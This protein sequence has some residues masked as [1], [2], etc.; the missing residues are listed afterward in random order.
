MSQAIT[1][2]DPATNRSDGVEVTITNLADGDSP[3][4]DLWVL[5]AEVVNH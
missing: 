4:N 3:E 1:Q 2:S 5:G